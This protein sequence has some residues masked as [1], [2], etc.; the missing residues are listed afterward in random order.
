MKHLRPQLQSDSL[1]PDFVFRSITSLK[2]S[3]NVTVGVSL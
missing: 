3:K 2:C 1:A